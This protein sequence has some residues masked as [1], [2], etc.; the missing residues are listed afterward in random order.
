[1]LILKISLANNSFG[2]DVNEII[3]VIPW[4]NCQKINFAPKYVLGIINYRD[5]LVPVIDLVHLLNEV[6][7]TNKISSRII[8]TKY[9]FEQKY[10]I[11]WSLCQK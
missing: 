2:I 7:A 8:I 10:Q 11:S 3:E 9:E 6:S 1:M 5:Q 4:V